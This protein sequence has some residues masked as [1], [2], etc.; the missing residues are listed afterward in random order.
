MTIK[1]NGTH[2]HLVYAD[3]VNMLGGRVRT[4]K[5]NRETLVVASKEIRLVVNAGKTKYIVMSRD[6]NSRRSHNIKNDTQD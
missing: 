1:L 2:Q 5:V 6:Q 3:N 4:V